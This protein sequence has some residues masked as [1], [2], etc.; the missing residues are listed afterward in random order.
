MVTV[1]QLQFCYY[2]GQICNFWQCIIV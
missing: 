2:W 1:V